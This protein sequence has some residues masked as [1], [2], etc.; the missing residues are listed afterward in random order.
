LAGWC[1][2]KA[3][4][5][6]PPI[7]FPHDDQKHSHIPLVLKAA[8]PPV[9]SRPV[10]PGVSAPESSVLDEPAVSSPSPLL[11]ALLWST[12]TS[13]TSTRHL[14][15][16]PDEDSIGSR[17]NI[18]HLGRIYRLRHTRFYCAVQVTVAKPPPPPILVVPAIRSGSPTPTPTPRNVVL[19]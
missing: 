3:R 17:R 9:G 14:S 5:L 18:Q 1:A 7:T 2:S 13:S 10:L 19:P 16:I 15:S 8:L 12:L 11:L 6:P 4:L